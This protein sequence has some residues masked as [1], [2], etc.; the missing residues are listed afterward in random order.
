MMWSSPA[1]T[2]YREDHAV[3]VKISFTTPPLNHIPASLS[4]KP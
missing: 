3:T 4:S 1:T 2:C